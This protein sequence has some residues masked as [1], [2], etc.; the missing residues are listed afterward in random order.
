MSRILEVV[1]SILSHCLA[2]LF[3]GIFSLLTL[4][5]FTLFILASLFTNSVFGIVRVL[6]TARR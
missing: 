4:T 5:G 6:S 2:A 1:S 3:V